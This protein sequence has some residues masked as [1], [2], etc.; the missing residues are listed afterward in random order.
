MLG[1]SE[2]KVKDVCGENKMM[3]KKYKRASNR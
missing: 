3:K 1:V 2:S